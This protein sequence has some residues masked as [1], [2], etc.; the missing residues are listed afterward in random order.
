MEAE[1]KIVEKRDMI[2]NIKL[3]YVEV[4]RYH[5]YK[6]RKFL[7]YN[8]WKDISQ[9]SDGYLSVEEAQERIAYLEYIPKSK[10]IGHFKINK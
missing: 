3:N 6:K 4:T 2:L 10:V 8:R 5:L 9:Y 1:Y 7:F